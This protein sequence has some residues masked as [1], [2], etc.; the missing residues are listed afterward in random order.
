MP[1]N[2]A[3]NG[4]PFPHP[5]GGAPPPLLSLAQ[6]RVCWARYTENVDPLLKIL[7]KP[8]VEG[9]IT[10]RDVH[11]YKS[12]PSIGALVQAVCLLAIIS[13][14]AKD[15][16]DNLESEKDELLRLCAYRLEQALMAAN[17]LDARDLTTMQ[18]LL[19][20]LY[21][22]KHKEDTKL[23]GL[24]GVTI[25][26]AARLGL[27]RDRVP[28]GISRLE[29]ELRRRLW[30]QLITLVDHPDDCGI[31]YAPPSVGA[32]T[33]LPLNVND[34]ELEQPQTCA[35]G[36]DRKGF[37]E[38]SFC[39]MQ[40]EI[41]RLF[42]RIR[43]ERAHASELSKTILNG[44]EERLHSSRQRMETQYFQ[45]CDEPS[46]LAKFAADAVAM[47]L[48]KRRVLMHISPDLSSKSNPLS[49]SDYDHLFLL[50]IH[51]LELSRALQTARNFEKWRWLSGTYFQ[52]SVANFVVKDLAVRQASPATKRA[53][54][55]ING[56][57]DSWPEAT[58]NSPK[59]AVL[60][61]LIA[62][63]VRHRDEQNMWN[64]G[65][66]S[67][68]LDR[69]DRFVT[70][71][72]ALRPM[73]TADERQRDSHLGW[74]THPTRQGQYL[75][76][77]QAVDLDEFFATETSMYDGNFALDLDMV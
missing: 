63:A 60:K 10:V 65:A 72:E 51:V 50:A 71:R 53:W 32:D 42:N 54:N 5:L 48:T 34:S 35:V 12:H 25:F 49:Q 7:H 8:T 22:L 31:D 3:E 46:P 11:H 41:T 39:L 6:R 61:G 16:S 62:D 76:P 38:L 70:P 40:Y 66:S 21:H 13:M 57:L 59:A 69:N 43:F 73:N 29:V 19:L 20:Y 68:P 23:Y 44:A 15:V 64:L 77:S 17:F 2:L 28:S 30:W 14:P 47:I 58:R 37:T 9:L 18:A 33:R 24:R 74:P 36:N 26:L 67:S 52:W 75:L 4:F 56:I 55:V 27:N 1:T 45:D